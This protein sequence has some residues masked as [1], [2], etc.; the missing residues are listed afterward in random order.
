MGQI[1]KNFRTEQQ[2][3]DENIAFLGDL[4]AEDVEYTP[5][6][7]DCIAEDSQSA[8][9]HILQSI[10]ETDINRLYYLAYPR[11]GDVVKFNQTLFRW[12]IAYFDARGERFETYEQVL[13]APIV[14]RVVMIICPEDQKINTSKPLSL[15]D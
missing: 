15:K 1:D 4:R 12:Q 11:D 9:C 5:N 14:D 8:A 3:V 7:L 13:R 2:L 6:S 10:R